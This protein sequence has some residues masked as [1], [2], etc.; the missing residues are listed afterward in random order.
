MMK[1]PVR[2]C[3]AV[4][5][6]FF[7]CRSLGMIAQ[8]TSTSDA[9]KQTVLLITI[10]GFP[11]QMLHDPHLPMPTLRA[12]IAGGAVAESMQP[13]NPTITWPN[14]ST[15][16]TGVDARIHHN[17]ING[18]IE[19]PSDGS[20]P[21]NSLAATKQEMVHARTLYEAASDKGL[22]T[23]E[24][25]WVAIKDAKGVTWDFSEQA[26]PEDLISRELIA[27][28]TITADQLLH[29][30]ESN[31]AW[32]DWIRTAATEDV[33]DKHSPNFL[34]LHLAQT[35]AV[36]HE[37]GPSTTAAYEAFSSVD[38]CLHDIVEAVKRKGIFE[39]TTFIITSDHGFTVTRHTINPNVALAELGLV[40]RDG[41]VVRADAWVKSTGGTA[42][43]YIHDPKLRAALVP[44][45]KERLVKIPGIEQ[46]LTNAEARAYG[47]P[48]E[49]DSDQA[50]SLYW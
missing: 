2:P 18:L 7:F 34:M 5:L 20:I 43:L 4:L 25:H 35:D 28:G 29:F 27:K 9:R 24:I 6:F 50:P 15:L 10:D 30:Y 32:R 22:T 16:V 41:K 14:H 31:P 17:V 12:L 23:A 19:F 37:Y 3:P 39:S 47:I 46:V 11:A 48:A 26:R 38:G 8:D 40:H 45:I 42:L 36:E 21:V 33:I 1:L 44:R 49:G 13:I